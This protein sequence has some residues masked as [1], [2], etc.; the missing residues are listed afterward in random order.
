MQGI[1]VGDVM[2]RHPRAIKAG[3]SL[4][5][6]VDTLLAHHLPGLPVVNESN[7]VI[8]F[9]SEQDCLGHLLGDTYYDQG[10]PAVEDVMTREAMC[11]EPDHLL[12][13]LAE[14]MLKLRPKTFPVVQEGQLVGMISRSLVVQTLR[15][16]RDA[17]DRKK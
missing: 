15:K 16:D 12:V 2:A 5:E 7:H 14:R 6:V 13:D 1:T 17:M 3:T 9:V 8:G 10:A 4:P 11:V